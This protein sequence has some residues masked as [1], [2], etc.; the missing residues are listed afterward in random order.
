LLVYVGAK[1]T[2]SSASRMHLEFCGAWKKIPCRKEYW[3]IWVH[4]SSVKYAEALGELTNPP[5]NATKQKHSNTNGK[6]LIQ[7]FVIPLFGFW[8]GILY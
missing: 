1:N 5:T 4:P 6:V 2:G 3:S 8:P 7:F